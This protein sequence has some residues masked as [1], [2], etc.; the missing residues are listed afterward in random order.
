MSTK[1]RPSSPLREVL[2]A[3]RARFGPASTGHE[4]STSALVE[5]LRRLRVE[6]LP[7]QVPVD[8]L[9]PPSSVEEVRAFYKRPRIRYLELVECDDYTIGVFFMPRFARLPLHDHPQMTVASKL[10]YGT[11]Q[12]TSYTLLE[13]ARTA[14]E[15]GSTFECV[16]SLTMNDPS[17]VA[18]LTPTVA[19]VH[20]LWA[21]TDCAVLDV[22]S[23][24][25][26]EPERRCQ[27]Y[28]VRGNRV[29]PIE[30]PADFSCESLSLPAV[31]KRLAEIELETTY[32]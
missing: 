12:M 6:D 24:P 15:Q 14:Q 25:Y 1:A 20:E 16:K 30:E 21:L 29:V 9:Q 26:L 32:L 18:V 31:E 8:S 11:L 5:A 17:D 23:P 22:I 13:D 10:M 28:E 3:A 19:N 4:A 27:Y 7:L 2:L